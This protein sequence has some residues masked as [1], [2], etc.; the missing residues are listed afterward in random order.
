MQHTSEYRAIMSFIQNIEM[1]IALS[2]S[3]ID[4]YTIYE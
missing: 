3:E 2:P 4:E 1:F